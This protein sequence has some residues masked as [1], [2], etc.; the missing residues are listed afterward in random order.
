M[1]LLATILALVLSA[2]GFLAPASHMQSGT[3]HGI[4]APRPNGGQPPMP[5]CDPKYQNCD[6]NGNPH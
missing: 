4:T 1:H 3:P 6:Q 2:Y 5:T